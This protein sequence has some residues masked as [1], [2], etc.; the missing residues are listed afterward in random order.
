MRDLGTPV[1]PRRFFSDILKHS[2]S[3]HGSVLLCRISARASALFI[4]FRT[5]WRSPGILS[6]RVHRLSPNMLLYWQALRYGCESRVP[7]VR[8]W[9]HNPASSH[10]RFKA[11][12]GAEP[13]PL[14]WHYWQPCPEHYRDQSPESPTSSCYRVWRHLPCADADD[15]AIIARSLP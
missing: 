13:V 6:E 1:Y 8:L 2:M 9:S 3:P 12:W 4:A 11:Q 10:Y 15:R 14:F 7:L 5:T